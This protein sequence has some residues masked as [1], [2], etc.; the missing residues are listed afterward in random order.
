MFALL[1]PTF[2]A[3]ASLDQIKQPRKTSK[4]LLNIS[5]VSQHARKNLESGRKITEYVY[6][7]LMRGKFVTL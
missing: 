2:S 4:M 7:M 1:P 6:C 3:P 5:F